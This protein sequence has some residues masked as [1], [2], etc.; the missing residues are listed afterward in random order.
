MN[1]FKGLYQANLNNMKMNTIRGRY[2]NG[3]KNKH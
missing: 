3:Q 1:L 2:Q